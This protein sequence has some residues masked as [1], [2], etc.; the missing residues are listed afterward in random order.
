MPSK[1]RKPRSALSVD[2]APDAVPEPDPTR[3]VPRRRRLSLDDYV[4][5]VR[6]GDRGVLAQAITLVESG[7]SEHIV[8][9]QE[10]LTRLMPHTG[11]A[12]RVGITGV[13]RRGQ[14]YVHRDVRP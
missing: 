1:K 4:N 2:P 7:R 3:D 9:A 10:L 5:G 11:Q 14:E 12:Y 8:L 6:D 13:P